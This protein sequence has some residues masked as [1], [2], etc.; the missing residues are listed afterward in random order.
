MSS[1]PEDSAKRKKL[2]GPWLFL[3]VLGVILALTV[4]P[5][6]FTMDENHYLVSMLCLK[7]WRAA[8]PGTD[9]LPPSRELF[10]FD[11]AGTTIDPSQMPVRP[12]FPP[13]YAFMALPFSWFGWRG[14]VTMNLLAFLGTAALVYYVA[15][16][17][18]ERV[19]AAWLALAAFVFGS[20]S[21]EYAVGMWPHMVAV[22]LTFSAVALLLLPAT[23]GVPWRSFLA[24]LL[25]G[26]AIGVR[27][28][29][30]VLADLIALLVVLRRDRIRSA[31]SY[32]PGVALALGACSLMN[33]WRLGT[34]NPISK[35]LGY[36]Q[37][38][39]VSS[40]ATRSHFPFRDVVYSALAR[41]FDYA[42]WPADKMAVSDAVLPHPVTGAYL[43][44]GILRKA[45]VQSSPWLMLVFAGILLVW[46]KPGSFGRRTAAAARVFSL[47]VLGVVGL[48]A[49]AGYRTSGWNYNERYFLE[50][51]P[52]MSVLLA[53][54]IGEWRTISLKAWLSGFLAAALG[55]AA[56]LRLP[57]A[58]VPRLL[59]LQ[60]VPLLAGTGL[61]ILYVLRR[62]AAGAALQAMLAFC[63]AW[64]L[65]VHVADDVRGSLRIRAVH[66]EVARDVRRL[67]DPH[68]PAAIFA[69]QGYAYAVGP[70][71]LD[72]DL[73]VADL[74]NDS[75]QTAGEL[76]DAFLRQ[77][78]EV[79]IVASGVPREILA[80]LLVDRPA[81]FFESG[82]LRLIRIKPG[83]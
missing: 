32:L 11:P 72:Y 5:G 33:H 39:A 17:L 18:T 38:Q 62:P 29:N 71:M 15:R 22:F 9:G 46:L 42:L 12:R 67:L 30:V 58:D 36:T 77:G 63:L 73:V 6:S 25:A 82:D 8:V 26:L 49:L 4:V 10:S 53:L 14:L 64:A 69:Y 54:L 61:A 81:S 48:F 55:A 65:V 78:R 28:Q 2:A 43:A 1:P 76:I 79:V 21:I 19:E 45:W 70:L 60:Y 13:L 80:P 52:L 31:L 20:Y 47:L 37:I 57:A 44:D 16:R 35:G 68:R 40:V 66:A 34:W 3:V 23:E 74:V 59:A 7:E 24:G 27:Y 50:L 75:G 56:A 51:M 83:S 41:V